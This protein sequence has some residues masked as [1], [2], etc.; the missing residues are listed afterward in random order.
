MRGVGLQ[1][2]SRLAGVILRHERNCVL[3]WQSKLSVDWLKDGFHNTKSNL[4]IEPSLFNVQDSVF[5][6]Y[7]V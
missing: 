7:F 5:E 1:T 4:E 2:K 3:D 6:R